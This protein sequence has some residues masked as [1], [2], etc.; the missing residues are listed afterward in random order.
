MHLHFNYLKTNKPNHIDSESWDLI[1]KPTIFFETLAGTE[2]A[3]KI[4]REHRKVNRTTSA[5]L[6]NDVDLLF[7]NESYDGKDNAIINI[8]TYQ[9][10]FFCDPDGID[11]YPFGTDHCDFKFYLDGNDRLKA[12]FTNLKLI[13]NAKA[14][15]G[16]YDV[17]QISLVHHD[18]P[19]V[20]KL[21]F[22]SSQSVKHKI[23]M[24]FK[25]KKAMKFTL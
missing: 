4:V 22:I 25:S 24:Q 12:Y 23:A 6:Y 2:T 19:E 21:S 18:D 13:N 15:V 20:R 16:E 10:D 9:A 11:M 5:S 3:P 14:N 17:K 7:H 8:K 1:W